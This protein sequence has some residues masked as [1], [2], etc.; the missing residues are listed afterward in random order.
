MGE[1]LGRAGAF[2]VF[3]VDAARRVGILTMNICVF[4]RD[5]APRV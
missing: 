4:K 5:M 3:D 1:R 2:D